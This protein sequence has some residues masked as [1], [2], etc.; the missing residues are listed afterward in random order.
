MKK[1]PMH[2][3]RAKIII[4]NSNLKFIIKRSGKSM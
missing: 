4:E 1:L 3:E 2:E